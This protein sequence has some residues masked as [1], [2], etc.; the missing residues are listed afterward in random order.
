MYFYPN[1]TPDNMRRKSQKR[2]SFNDPSSAVVYVRVSS[3]RQV[4]NT[5]LDS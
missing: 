3:D 4:D 2:Q 5:S 1:G